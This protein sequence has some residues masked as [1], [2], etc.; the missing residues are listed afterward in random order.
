MLL[1][2][3]SQVVGPIGYEMEV[4]SSLPT[5]LIH[6]TRVDISKRTILILLN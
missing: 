3:T 6:G 2:K 4:E 5:L 1:I